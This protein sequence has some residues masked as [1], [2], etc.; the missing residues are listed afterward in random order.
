MQ[1]VMERIT[2]PCLSLLPKR[3]P[4]CYGNMVPQPQ[5]SGIP[6]PLLSGVSCFAV[7]K[8][9]NC[10]FL[11]CFLMYSFLQILQSVKQPTTDSNAGRNTNAEAV[12]N[13]PTTT[14]GCIQS[15]QAGPNDGSLQLKTTF[16]TA[17]KWIL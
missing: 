12:L 13:R 6:F 7:H 16:N 15:R 8:Q 5:A 10:F 4:H 17:F 9:E 14:D 1:C 3:A 2:W 11:S